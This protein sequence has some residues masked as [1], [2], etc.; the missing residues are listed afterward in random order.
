MAWFLTV[1]IF[2]IINKITLKV[3]HYMRLNV[4][5]VVFNVKSCD[6]RLLQEKMLMTAF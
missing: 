2:M 1:G 6:Q 5:A 3:I 4:V